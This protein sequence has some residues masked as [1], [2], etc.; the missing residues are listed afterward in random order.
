MPQS[1]QPSVLLSFWGVRGF[2]RSLVLQLLLPYSVMNLSSV[3]F[4][5]HQ[6]PPLMLIFHQ[7]LPLFLLSLWFSLMEVSDREGFVGRKW[8]DC[9]RGETARG[10][11][12]RANKPPPSSA[13][14][15][16]RAGPGFWAQPK[17]FRGSLGRAIMRTHCSTPHFQL[18]SKAEPLQGVAAMPQDSSF[19]GNSFR[20]AVPGKSHF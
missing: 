13:A 16:Y 20:T 11:W 2:S 10:V 5:L 8:S 1:L 6:E 7:G 3:E 18:Q 4:S 9:H 19:G 12:L 15:K 17:P 14:L